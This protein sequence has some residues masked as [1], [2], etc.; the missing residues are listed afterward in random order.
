MTPD[1]AF[2]VGVGRSGSSIFHRIMCRH[3][4]VAWLSRV[5]ERKP[6]RPAW[7]RLLMR[8]IDVP[9]VGP[10]LA[11]HIEPSECYAY[12]NRLYPGFSEPARDL[13]G[14]DVTNDVCARVQAAL[15]AQRTSRRTQLLVK[16]TGWPRLGFLHRVF[17]DAKFIH[18]LRDG[19]PVAA[20]FLKVAWWGGWRGP[21]TWRYGTLTPEQDAEWR[22]HDRSFVSLAGIQWKILMDAMEEAKRAC[23]SAS[24]LEIKYEDVCADP[25]AHFRH[26]TEFIGLSWTARFERAVR[27]ATLRCENTKWRHDFTVEQQHSLEAVLAGHLARYG[28]ETN[29]P[30]A[31]RVTMF[32]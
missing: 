6:A 1:P 8:A 29:N 30:T 26:A 17:P 22:R 7:N 21:F 15:G 25:I 32:A 28:Y 23:P 18:I 11:D 16:I 31:Q 24:V 5:L 13:V 4:D 19:R 27:E 10:W 12:W 2:I 9:L 3:P 20:S 14:G